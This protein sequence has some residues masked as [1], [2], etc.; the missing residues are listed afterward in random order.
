M[1][2]IADHTAQPNGIQVT[3]ALAPMA[4]ALPRFVAHA[5]MGEITN[6]TTRAPTAQAPAARA[7]ARFFIGGKEGGEE[8]VQGGAAEG[9]WG[10]GDSFPLL[11]QHHA[12]LHGS[13]TTAADSAASTIADPA[14]SVAGGALAIGSAFAGMCHSRSS[15]ANCHPG[16]T[17]HAAYAGV[18]NR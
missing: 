15:V 17:L 1:S 11:S 16:D 12:P 4:R 10:G 7:L 18:H 13:D 5:N 9:W 3:T 2:E 8:A 6:C 14:I